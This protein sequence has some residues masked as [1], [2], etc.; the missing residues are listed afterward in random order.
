MF[1][2]D[3]VEDLWGFLSSL[4]NLRTLDLDLKV[5]RGIP[6]FE[7]SLVPSDVVF[8]KLESLRVTTLLDRFD[9]LFPIGL[10]DS[11]PSLKELEIN[12]KNVRVF[13]T[14]KG[15]LVRSRVGGDCFPES[16]VGS[17]FDSLSILRIHTFSWT[18]EGYNWT[19]FINA[20]PGLKCLEIFRSYRVGGSKDPKT[21]GFYYCL[22]GLET[23]V[24]EYGIDFGAQYASMQ[25]ECT[26]TDHLVSHAFA[27][28]KYR[29]FMKE[30][31]YVG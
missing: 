21:G 29:A 1:E 6:P 14:L 20:L 18:Y 31:M 24:I 23:K 22:S 11:Q 12:S 16:S 28:L 30:H 25:W 9:K 5:N 19:A 27:I 10:L 3:D 7:T 26:S 8:E 2:A 15:L 13:R 17:Q 4:P